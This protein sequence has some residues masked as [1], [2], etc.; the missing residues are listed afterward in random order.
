[1]KE[2][3]SMEMGEP[4]IAIGV[5]HC[6]HVVLVPI[7]DAVKGAGSRGYLVIW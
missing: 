1:M 7:R 5:G 2:K 4:C 3:W 6:I